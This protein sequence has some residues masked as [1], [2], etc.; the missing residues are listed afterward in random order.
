MTRFSRGLEA[1]VRKAQ[2]VY[3]GYR[4]MC[5][6]PTFRLLAH[7]SVKQAQSDNIKYALGRSQDAWQGLQR[8][9]LIL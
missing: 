1:L 6:G 5:K 9:E 8:P 7:L 4:E 3:E 2:N